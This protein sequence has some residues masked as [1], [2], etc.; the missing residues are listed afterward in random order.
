MKG[1]GWIKTYGRSGWIR[2]YERV[3]IDKNIWKNLI[4][5]RYG[6][7]GWKIIDGRRGLYRKNGRME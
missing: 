1:W 3:G 6:S 7:F 5:Q 4:K 2:R